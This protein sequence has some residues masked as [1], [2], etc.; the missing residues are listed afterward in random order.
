[1]GGE[2]PY[3]IVNM[4]MTADGKV[5]TVA[6]RGARIST[7]A[8][9]DRVNALRAEVDAIMVGGRTL[10]A[11]DPRLTVRSA[12]LVETRR[13]EGRL[14]QPV[15]I[16]VV[17][18]IPDPDTGA[19]LGPDSRFLHGAPAPVIV[20]T[21]ERTQPAVR[22]R[23]VEARAEV[24][25]LGERRVDLSAALG[26]LGRRG[27]R[28]LLVEGG[29]TLVAELLRL[30]LVDEMQLFVGPLVFGGRDA[31]TPVEGPGF[32]SDSAVRLRPAGVVDLGPEG[33]VLRYTVVAGGLARPPD[34]PGLAGRRG[35]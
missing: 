10:L 23:L 25:I 14:P 32:G 35:Q 5:D 15:R 12:A 27:I 22:R 24:V 20:L 17:S 1:M 4:A 21:S 2:R 9:G 26:E 31:P 7:D 13:R 33:V 19:D 11:E 28:R 6:R 8:D 30:G 29:G 34:P 18:T 3:V 16:G